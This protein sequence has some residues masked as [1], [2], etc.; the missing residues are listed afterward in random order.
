MITYNGYFIFHLP[1]LT[2]WLTFTSAEV[3][4]KNKSKMEARP[5]HLSYWRNSEYIVS[6]NTENLILDEELGY[7]RLT[8]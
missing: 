5:V 7:V 2:D 3:A 6:T 4:I 1:K 8:L